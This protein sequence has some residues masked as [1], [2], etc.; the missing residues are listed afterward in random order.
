MMV[1]ASVEEAKQKGF[2]QAREKWPLE[3][4]WVEHSVVAKEAEREFLLQ[5]APVISQE[6]FNRNMSL[7]VAL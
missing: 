7:P 6:E 4:G 5:A 1:A 2:E 3:D